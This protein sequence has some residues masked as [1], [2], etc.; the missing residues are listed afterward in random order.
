MVLRQFT[1]KYIHLRKYD[2]DGRLMSKGGCTIAYMPANN[3][4]TLYLA[5][6]ARCHNDEPFT[7]RIGREVAAGR[8]A[9]EYNKA[10]RF[11]VKVDPD[12]SVPVGSQI[13]DQFYYEGKLSFLWS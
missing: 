2:Y 5:T 4:R 10:E 7:K 12:D 8:L 9:S 13:T 6:L 3:E 11:F 1:P